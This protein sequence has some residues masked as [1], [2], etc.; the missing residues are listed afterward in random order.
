[1][2][3]LIH[4]DLVVWAVDGMWMWMLVVFDFAVR[5]LEMK[6]ARFKSAEI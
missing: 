4:W 3:E 5:D 1:M 6:E 2:L